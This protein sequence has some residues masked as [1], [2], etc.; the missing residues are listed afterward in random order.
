MILAN[1]VPDGARVG[2]ERRLELGP[3]LFWSFIPAQ[4]SIAIT[5]YPHLSTI[6]LGEYVSSGFCFS[7]VLQYDY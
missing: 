3:V 7:A 1:Q 2:F 6:G 4:Y 5:S